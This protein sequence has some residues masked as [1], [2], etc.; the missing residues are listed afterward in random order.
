M[1][2]MLNFMELLLEFHRTQILLEELFRQFHPHS[3]R[4][5]SFK[6]RTED[7]NSKDPRD[8]LNNNKVFSKAVTSR[9]GL[10]VVKLNRQICKTT[11]YSSHKVQYLVI[12]VKLEFSSCLNLK[13]TLTKTELECS[14]AHPGVNF[15]NCK[16][17]PIVGKQVEQTPPLRTVQTH[18][19]TATSLTSFRTTTMVRFLI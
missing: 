12:R 7:P 15:T 1:V 9:K 8:L 4:E 17:A 2:W 13:V 19:H 10:V 18:L 11:F 16:I 14:L 3:L 5:T 6:D